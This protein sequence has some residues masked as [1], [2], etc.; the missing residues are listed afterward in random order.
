MYKVLVVTNMLP[1]QRNDIGYYGVFVKEQA[2]ALERH[3]PVKCDFFA[4]DGFKSKINYLRTIPAILKK[5]SS[6]NYDAI[7]VHYGLSGLFLVANPFRKWSNIVLTF[8]GGDILLDQKK[9][10]Q[11]FLSKLIARKANRLIVLN[12]KMKEATNKLHRHVSLIP[13]GVD[14]HFFAGSRHI[15]NVCTLVFA[16][17]PM[18]WVKNYPLFEKVVAAYERDFGP[19]KTVV[20][21]GLSRDEIRRILLTSTALIMTSHSEGSP[22]IVKEAMSCDLPV[23]SSNVGDVK[24]FLADTPGTR[25]FN[26]DETPSTI[27][28][29][30]DAAIRES[31]QCH[32][33]RRKRVFETGLNQEHIANLIYQEY[34]ALS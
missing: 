17:D 2:D 29:K 1:S 23:I 21:G 12:E 6:N 34:K 27:A 33:L 31:V 26:L 32:G 10:I 13:C 28:H 4:I 19:V 24:D 8:H 20:L 25:I 15:D 18:R 7:H 30:I 22:Q 3:T 5:I 14:T 16:G 11:V 9:F